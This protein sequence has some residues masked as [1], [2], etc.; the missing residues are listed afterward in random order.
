[1]AAQNILEEIIYQLVFDETFGSTIIN[2][3]N[4]EIVLYNELP[5]EDGTPGQE[6]GVDTA[7]SVGYNSVPI[8]S[9][10]S[11]VFEPVGGAQEENF[12]G[13]LVTTWENQTSLNFGT[14]SDSNQWPLIVGWGI[15]DTSNG[16]IY[17]ADQ[18]I[19]ASLSPVAYSVQPQQDFII[20]V[21]NFKIGI[22]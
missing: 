22:D 14:N 1:M 3:N 17:L 11:N 8:V 16:D 10:G 6:F 4:L 12:G 15:K 9:N 19:N 18:F 7:I 13:S 21:G 2:T 20:P 5:N